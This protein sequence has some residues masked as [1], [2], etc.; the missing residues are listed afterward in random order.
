MP[1]TLTASEESA[2]GSGAD[3]LGA[4]N[5]YATLASLKTLLGITATTYDAD[6]L[7]Y[8]EAASRWVDAACLRH[9]YV[10]TG[11]RYF[12]GTRTDDLP[13]DDCMSVTSFLADSEVDG[14]FDGE[15]WTEGDEEDY[16]LSP[17]NG[18]PKMGAMANS[19]GDYAFSAARRRYK[20]TGQWGYGD[21]ESATPYDASG[22]TVTLATTTGTTATLSA[23]GTIKAGHTLLVESEQLYVAAVTSDGTKQATV[24][25]G[26]N[27]TTAATH[28]AK[29]A[30]VYRYPRNVQRYTVLLAGDAYNGMDE[31]GM[32]SEGIGTYRYK[33]GKAAD[34]L[35][36][37]SRILGPFVRYRA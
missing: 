21:G 27:G 4:R 5:L 23:E 11:T 15:T 19:W 30:S 3:V 33:V 17:L 14:T 34:R 37:E 12:D 8:L 31:L 10:E 35:V 7:G 18:W 16:V 28:A 13:L 6:L 29:A 9:F 25:R 2:S 20:V 22:I 1:I 32:E 24:T 36:Q 26:V